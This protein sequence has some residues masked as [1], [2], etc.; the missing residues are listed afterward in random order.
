MQ[1]W[2]SPTDVTN[3]A[4]GFLSFHTSFGIEGSEEQL[5]GFGLNTI[6][7]LERRIER[8]PVFVEWYIHPDVLPED[9]AELVH[10]ASHDQEYAPT[11]QKIL[12]ATHE[13]V[14]EVYEKR[15]ITPNYE[16]LP[17]IPILPAV[18]QI[19]G[20]LQQHLYEALRSYTGTQSRG[21]LIQEMLDRSKE[22]AFKCLDLAD[23]ANALAQQY[24]AAH[25]VSMF[26][27]TQP[28]LTE[29]VPAFTREQVARA[30]YRAQTQAYEALGIPH[31]ASLV[32]YEAIL[33]SLDEISYAR[34]LS[35]ARS[36]IDSMT[37]SGSSLPSSAPSLEDLDGPVM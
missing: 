35:N 5:A 27:E 19:L 13:E 6:N 9:F 7:G 29:G 31:G 36:A 22:N 17:R 20:P 34:E 16:E 37:I 21:P 2:F 25:Y 1:Q 8:P 33:T 14:R 26:I 18:P 10:R 32:S 24:T 15:G 12:S 28:P 4:D 3:I 11:A 30:Q 23:I